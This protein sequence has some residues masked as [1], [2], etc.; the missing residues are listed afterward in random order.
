MVV[1]GR[2]TKSVVHVSK[3]S[4]LAPKSEVSLPDLATKSV[5]SVP[6]LAAK[7]VVNV[8]APDL[9][10]NSV[11]NIIDRAQDSRPPQQQD[12]VPLKRK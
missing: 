1:P 5:V 8:T 9:A 6:E 7:S 2:A 3:D 10:T 4:V 12:A 11:V